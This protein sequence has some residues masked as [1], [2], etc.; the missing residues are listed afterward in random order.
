MRRTA[1]PIGTEKFH[2]K[3]A[4]ME[5]LAKHAKGLLALEEPVALMGDFNVIPDGNRL[6]RSES[7]GRRCAVP[8][9]VACKPEK[10]RISGLYR[11][12]PRLP[13][14]DA[15]IYVLGLS[16]GRLVEGPRHPHRP[17]PVV[18]AGRRSPQGLW[19][20]QAC[21][22]P[23]EAVGSRS[24]LVRAGGVRR[25]PDGQW[26]TGTRAGFRGL[27]NSHTPIATQATIN[28]IYRNM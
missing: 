12:I 14:R 3:L 20:R 18:A 27:G 23:G 9:S 15:S 16:G 25:S 19:N 28:P 17:Y 5:R 26:L 6:P 21:A 24:C 2:Y 8:A 10:H 1:I 22:R 13:L 4:W 7:M 11:R